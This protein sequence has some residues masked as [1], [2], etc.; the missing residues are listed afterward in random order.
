MQFN[1]N[2]KREIDNY[3]SIYFIE[4]K[5]FKGTSI[6]KAINKY[7]KEKETSVINHFIKE[8]FKDGLQKEETER[9]ITIERL[10]IMTKMMYGSNVTS[11][12]CS[13]DGLFF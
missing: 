6:R 4:E 3:C 9:L 8:N 1:P 5:Y 7:L 10:E 2:P 12:A 11:I 13:I